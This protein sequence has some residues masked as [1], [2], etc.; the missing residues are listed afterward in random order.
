MIGEIARGNLLNS[1]RFLFCNTDKLLSA[2]QCPSLE[3][4]HRLKQLF[5]DLISLGS[6][7]NLLFYV[8]HVQLIDPERPSERG[9]GTELEGLLRYRKVL[10]DYPLIYC[11]YH[12]FAENR[13][14]LFR[15]S[16]VECVDF[17]DVLSTFYRLQN[18][19]V[20]NPLT[21]ADTAISSLYGFL[22][23]TRQYPNIRKVTLDC[24]SSQEPLAT[25]ERFI[26]FL[27]DCRGLTELNLRWPGFSRQNFYDHL[28]LILSLRPLESLY[29]FEDP[30]MFSDA[31]NQ[32]DFDGY[33]T[34]FIYLHRL[35]TNLMPKAMAAGYLDR[36]RVGSEFNFVYPH[37]SWKGAF[38]HNYIRRFDPRSSSANYEVLCEQSNPKG[39]AMRSS[40][41]AHTLDAAKDLLQKHLENASDPTVV[42]P[43]KQ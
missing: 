37:V 11:H 12:N 19:L 20:R 4:C 3:D 29:L 40:K 34:S 24:S 38:C 1:V 16:T 36:M 9:P 17:C 27:K 14:P 6:K 39:P 32:L 10:F 7:R 30:R 22:Q 2:S 21:R 8:N 43:A 18:P 42:R 28:P 5:G 26:D 35:H 15:C 33:F 31:A 25:A 41:Q 23:F 13:L